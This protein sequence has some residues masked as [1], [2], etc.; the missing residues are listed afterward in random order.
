MVRQAGFETEATIR[1]TR[2]VDENESLAQN[3]SVGIDPVYCVST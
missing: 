3:N 1:L 2:K